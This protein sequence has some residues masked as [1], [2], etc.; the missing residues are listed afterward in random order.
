MPPNSGRRDYAV[1]ITGQFVSFSG[2]WMQKT[3]VG[4]LV[5]ELTQ[6]PAWVGAIAL[7]DLV[8]A[9]WVAPLSGAVADRNNPYRLI[10]LTQGLLMVLTATLWAVTAMGMASVWLVLAWAVLDSTLQGFNQ[11]ARMIVVSSLTTPDRLSQ[12]IAGN[13]IAVNLARSTGP[14]LAGFVILHGAIADVM[15]LNAAS[16]LVTVGSIIL[17]R[18]RIDRPGQASKAVSFRSDIVS[19]YAYLWRSAP[20]ATIFA[21]T[22]GFGLLARPFTELFAALAGDV[23]KGGPDTLGMLMSAQGIGAMVGALLML[24]KRSRLALARIIFGAAIGI[25]VSL[26]VFSLSQNLVLA[27]GAMA[28]AGFFHVTCNIAMQS[29]VQMLSAPEM[30]GRIVALYALI[31]RCGPSLGAFLMGVGAH[32]VPLQVLIGAAAAVFIVLVLGLVPRA[33]RTYG[34]A[35]EPAE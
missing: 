16:Y 19:G 29:M 26:I 11:P 13:A 1:F 6:S 14:V 32:Y 33:R 3:A 17:L 15:L 9:L 25:G 7:C 10:L 30:R 22:I 4:W 34:L 21:L 28:A 8:S 5:W 12:A 35:A 31:F 23:L 18:R 27:V 20:I 2:Y 24:R